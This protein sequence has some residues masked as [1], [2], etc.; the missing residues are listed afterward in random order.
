MAIA[1]Y[2]IPALLAERRNKDPHGEAYTSINYDVDPFGVAET[3]SWDELYDRTHAVAAK[4]LQFG[5]PGDRAVILAP[6]NLDYVV[7]FLGAIRAGFIA[8]PLSAPLFG[9]HD[10][11]IVGT[12]ADSTPVAILTT[13]AIVGE[14]SGYAKDQPHQRAPKV[15][16]V[17]TLDIDFSG[18]NLNVD[19]LPKTAYL[20]YTSGSTRA[21][22]GV[23]VTHKN[24]IRNIEQLNPDYFGGNKIDYPSGLRAVSWLPLY[25]DMGLIIGIFLGVM[26]GCPTTL[27]SPISFMLKPARWIQQLATDVAAAED[28][29]VVTAAPNFAYEL[30]ARRTTDEDLAGKDLRH[31]RVMINGAERVHGATL[32]RFQERFAPF[33]LTPTAMRSSYGL[34]ESTIYVSSTMADRPAKSVRFDLEKLA[35]GHAELCDDG[36]SELVSVGPPRSTTVRIVDPETFVEKPAGQVGEVWLHG[37][38]VT[39]GYWRNPEQTARVFRG[40]IVEPTPGTP[41]EPWLRTADLGM[42]FDGELF[43]V[44]RIKDLVIVDG[45]NHYP[46][47]IE[48][49]VREVTHGRV[50]AISVPDGATER[51]VVIAELKNP[52]RRDRAELDQIEQQVTAAISETHRVRVS[53]LLLVGP[54]SLPLTTSGKVRRAACGDEYRRGEFS[55][56]GASR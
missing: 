11:R 42:M 29:W 17:D 48:T 34:A 26:S 36:G 14:I 7:A 33:K 12:L 21:P 41:A 22:A 1:E 40:K 52:E 13:S 37:D 3:I 43:I 8:V 6:Q 56:L 35:A 49:T 28:R 30:A 55:R 32:R 46:D 9:Q 23:E 50:A 38:H 44:G 25:H 24:V 5:S 53:D 27:L 10:E 2:S 39:A 19:L 4:L 54:G 51:L 45:R 47:D 20:Q 15:I 18:D 31:V 16:E